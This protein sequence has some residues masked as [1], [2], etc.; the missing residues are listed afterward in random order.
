[1]IG[2]I[3]AATLIS[4]SF[5]GSFADAKEPNLISQQKNFSL[6]NGLIGSLT[7]PYISMQS[8]VTGYGQLG[9]LQKA[10][11]R[12]YQ[13]GATNVTRTSNTVIATYGGTEKILVWCRGPEAIVT[14]SGNSPTA[15]KDDLVGYL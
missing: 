9:C 7:A 4:S 10:E 5:L 14:V 13:I 2:K 3:I 8:V 1:M 6:T 15:I 12:I 11:S